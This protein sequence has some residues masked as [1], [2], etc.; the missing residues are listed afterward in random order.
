MYFWG[1]SSRGK[2]L[3]WFCVALVKSW[4]GTTLAQCLNQSRVSAMLLSD[5]IAAKL[6]RAVSHHDVWT[7]W[8]ELGLKS[9]MQKI[10][11]DGDVKFSFDSELLFSRDLLV[12]TARETELEI[13]RLFKWKVKISSLCHFVLQ[14]EY[15]VWLTPRDQLKNNLPMRPRESFEPLIVVPFRVNGVAKQHEVFFCIEDILCGNMAWT[16]LEG[17]GFG[18]RF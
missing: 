18:T 12:S 7:A 11:S 10:T 1:L 13:R 14:L 3:G 2:L 8:V 16:T 9:W 15:L 6:D 4:L 17:C 5:L